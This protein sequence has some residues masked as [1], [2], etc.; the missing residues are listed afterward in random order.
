M[1]LVDDL[2]DII[3]GCLSGERKSQEKLYKLFSSRM[4]G[5][6]L[7]YSNDFDDAKDILQEGFI[8]VFTKLEQFNERGSFE[9]WIRR[10]MINTALEKYRSHL[11]LYSLTEQ[12][13]KKNELIYEEVFENLS[14]ADLVK[15][16]QELPPRYRMV[17]NL[18]AIE[19]YAHKEISEMLGITVGTSKSNL[20]RA[21]VIMQEKVKR[22]Y[23]SSE[24]TGV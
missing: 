6:C 20:A 10:I 22:F 15:L 17:F 1:L 24:N 13:V 11:H 7:Q 16:I 21:R 12:D 4:F 23:S 8:K 3:K 19:G 5:V 14:A 2:K 9:G 18:H